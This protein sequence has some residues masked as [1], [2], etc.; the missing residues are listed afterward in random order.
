MI[1][2]ENRK[3]VYVVNQDVAEIREVT[4]GTVVG[5]RVL[6]LAGI[7]AGDRYI[8]AGQRNVADGQRVVE[9]EVS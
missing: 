1:D 5:D 3:V 8:V 9:S 7:E 2:F 4:L 6:V